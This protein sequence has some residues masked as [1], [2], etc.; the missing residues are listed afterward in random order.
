MFR[1]VVFNSM[2]QDGP[3]FSI[4]FIPSLSFLS[5]PS[6]CTAM[7]LLT[8]GDQCTNHDVLPPYNQKKYP[9]HCS[10]RS[11]RHPL[12][13]F[14]GS[15]F[16]KIFFFM[17]LCTASELSQAKTKSLSPLECTHSATSTSKRRPNQHIPGSP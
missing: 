3:Y 5:L 6:P 2:I 9:C 1:I 7:F 16:L 11:Q 4:L 8:C 14:P 15:Q 10:G 12:V 13:V 17:P